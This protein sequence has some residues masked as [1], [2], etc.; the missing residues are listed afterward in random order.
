MQVDKSGLFGQR[1]DIDYRDPIIKKFAKFDDG[2]RC[3]EMS[4]EEVVKKLL[5]NKYSFRIQE[6]AEMLSNI[7]GVASGVISQFPRA[8]LVKP[9][10]AGLIHNEQM[11]TP[12][13]KYP[14]QTKAIKEIVQE[15]I[16]ISDGEVKVALEYELANI[17]LFKKCLAEEAQKVKAAS[18]EPSFDEELYYLSMNRCPETTLNWGQLIQIHSAGL[19]LRHVSEQTRGEREMAEGCFGDAICIYGG[20]AGIIFELLE[21]NALSCNWEQIKE[22]IGC[23][24]GSKTDTIIRTLKRHIDQISVLLS[25]DDK[26]R[27]TS[28]FEA[29]IYKFV[30]SSIC[31]FD[32]QINLADPKDHFVEKRLEALATSSTFLIIEKNPRD[33]MPYDYE[34]Y[35]HL[36]KFGKGQIRSNEMKTMI[37]IPKD[38]LIAALAELNE[39]EK[40]LTEQVIALNQAAIR[41]V[42]Q[43]VMKCFLQ[44]SS[45]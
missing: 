4:V 16:Q 5:K 44:L 25:D 22:H 3:E 33:L 8:D 30:Q 43:Q 23:E 19:G 37:T 7:R 29:M 27:V 13:W 10:V 12:L 6:F 28:R 14:H 35:Y 41:A 31:N 1:I 2:L 38:A 34:N 15:A 20:T 39:I 36:G 32:H 26:N 18:I 17:R 11:T 24:F 42:H 9:F 21:E 45:K 40:D